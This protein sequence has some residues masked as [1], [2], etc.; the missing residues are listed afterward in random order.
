[1]SSYTNQV[2]MLRSSLGFGD[3]R[4]K[5]MLQVSRDTGIERSNICWFIRKERLAGRIYPMYKGYCPVS[6]YRAVFYTNSQQVLWTYYVNLT[7]SRWRDLNDIEIRLLWKA[8]RD[9]VCLGFD[10]ISLRVPG[11]IKERWE[12]VIKPFIDR[13][14]IL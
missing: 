5:T 8:I 2:A 14:V 1:M 9:Y 7:T 6:G 10:D 4:P 3:I 12:T 11:C 13:E